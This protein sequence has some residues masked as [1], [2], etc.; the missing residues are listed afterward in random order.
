MKIEWSDEIKVL[1]NKKEKISF[2][3]IFTPL[4]LKVVY[5]FLDFNPPLIVFILSCIIII[6]VAGYGD[7]YKIKL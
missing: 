6:L 2:Y 4:C 3:L 7:L 5:S 1:K